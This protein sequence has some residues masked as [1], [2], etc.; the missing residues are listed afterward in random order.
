M[1]LNIFKDT[2]ELQFTVTRHK[3]KY[4]K[5]LSFTYNKNAMC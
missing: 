5:R 3:Q 4:D 1:K 2:D